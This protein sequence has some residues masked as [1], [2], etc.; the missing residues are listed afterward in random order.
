MDDEGQ[1]LEPADEPQQFGA[2][3]AA[4]AE[5]ADRATDEASGDAV[6]A[7][8]RFEEESQGPAPTVPHGADADG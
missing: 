7:Q 1:N 2:A 3:A 8:R 4:D 6:E 5:I